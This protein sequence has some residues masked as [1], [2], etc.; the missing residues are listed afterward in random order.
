[1]RD[2]DGDDVADEYVVVYEDLGN[3]EHGLHG[4][5]WGP[6]GK[7]YMSKGNS[8]GKYESGPGADGKIAP[9]AFRELA[10][11]EVTG[12]TPNAPPPKTFTP[13][14]Y[15]RGYHDPAD[16]W[17]RE[18]GV[19]RCDPDGSHLEIIA[20]GFRNPFDIT[21][22]AGFECL[23][24]DND[25][26]LGDRVFMPFPGAHFGWGHPWN[27]DWFGDHAPCVPVSAPVF[28]G[29][30]TGIIHGAGTAFPSRYR[31]VFFVNDWGRKVTYVLRPRWRGALLAADTW[32]LEEFAVEPSRGLYKPTDIEVGPDGALYIG[33][34]GRGYGVEWRRGPD[35]TR[36]QTNEGRIFRVRY[37]GIPLRTR[38]SWM[39]PKRSRPLAEWSTHELIDDLSERA[40]PVW[41][42]DAQAELIRRDASN[43]ANDVLFEAIVSR[44]LSQSQETWV[45]WAF[46]RSAS[47]HEQAERN[48]ARW[49]A[50]RNASLNLRLQSIRILAHRRR[51]GLTDA[52]LPHAVARALNNAEPRLRFA[53]AQAIWQAG[54]VT[55]RIDLVARAAIETERLTAYTLRSALA[56]FLST[57]AQ[58]ELLAYDAPRLRLAGL[59]AL[60]GKNALEVEEV[61]A[62]AE[63]DDDDVVRDEALRWLVQAGPIVWNKK[64]PELQ[65][66]GGVS[67]SIGRLRSTSGNARVQLLELIASQRPSG[68]DWDRLRAEYDALADAT[69]N[70]RAAYLRALASDPR[71]LALLLKRLGDDSSDIRTAAID[72][73]V[74]HG[75]R[76]REAV[77]HRFVEMRS[78]EQRIAAL[79]VLDRVA[80]SPAKLHAPAANALGRVYGD[81]DDPRVRGR[82]TRAFARADPESVTFAA[83]TRSV[84]ERVLALAAADP[85]PRVHNAAVALAAA[86]GSRIELAR[87]RAPAKANAVLAGVA[88]ADAN[89]G[90][91]LFYDAQ[92]A[93]CSGCHRIDGD[94]ASFAPDLSDIGL[95]APLEVIAQS[96]L[97]PSAVITEGFRA[98]VVATKNG[99]AHTGM[100]VEETGQQL[101]L[102]L[103]DGARSR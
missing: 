62:I 50:G 78:L 25:Q 80:G 60:L 39:T 2:L 56:D 6:D 76:G 32:D 7:L 49:A 91:A 40:L 102:A 27:F 46:G 10:G 96:L 8:K 72:G 48:L 92:R 99:E 22:D 1:M 84:A 4:L 52:P 100:I 55:K 36:E 11:V 17:G 44:E 54:D 41:R 94:G 85:D 57:N 77:L 3:I 88:A 66:V 26:N 61:A 97:E 15:K 20:R 14:T 73:L 38:V 71:A 79:T 13:E 65:G 18:G 34:W 16:D 28:H 70:E 51:V 45:A 42:V 95:R 74:S 23:G 93:N 19:L 30:G 82:V 63:R 67:R 87:Q 29:S 5:N 37:D 12:E 98:Y 69:S 47:R 68:G 83:G 89:R 86:L 31:N 35:G 9:R 64:K 53:A 103:T 59:L 24:T 75:E 33:G 90:R 81:T 21:F 101:T 58:R 43:T